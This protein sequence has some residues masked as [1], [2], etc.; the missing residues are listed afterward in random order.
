MIASAVYLSLCLSLSLTPSSH[1]LSNVTLIID[2]RHVYY[3]PLSS[4]TH[5]HT[6][7]AVPDFFLTAIHTKPGSS[8]T[9]LELNALVNVYDQATNM[10][11][12]TN[13]VILGDFN[14]GCSYLSKTRY[15]SLDLVTDS[16]FTWLI[17]N[18]ADT[19]T[20][21]SVCPYDRYNVIVS[22]KSFL[23]GWFDDLYL[24]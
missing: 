22:Q 21:S 8:I 1:T 16:R 10:F 5:T 11:R 15:R 24:L 2:D 6:H 4:N 14:A 7:T 9:Y 17:G 23:A 18:D 19:T 3:L 13:G 12:T 20:A